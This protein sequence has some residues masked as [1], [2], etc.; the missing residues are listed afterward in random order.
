L[1]HDAFA[2][3]I[4]HDEAVID[5]AAL[6]SAAKAGDEVAEDI[7]THCLDVW[8]AAVISYIH[9]Y[10]PEIVILGGGILQSAADIIPYIQERVSARAWTPW[11]KV[12]IVRSALNDAA[13]I[14]G[15]V[16]SLQ[17]KI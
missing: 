3:S 8:A 15:A 4:L 1:N 16:Y 10:D 14:L 11:G 17:H 12:R 7:K 13:A 6:F 9:A 2:A 5:F